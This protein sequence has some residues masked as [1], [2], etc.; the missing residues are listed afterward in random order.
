MVGHLGFIWFWAAH[1]FLVHGPGDP[2]ANPGVSTR[3]SRY[4]LHLLDDSKLPMVCMQLS[5]VA[6][7][8]VIITPYGNIRRSF[9]HFSRLTSYSAPAM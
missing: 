3:A 9:D 2:G 4:A 1:P 5:Q 6:K 7:L 8:L